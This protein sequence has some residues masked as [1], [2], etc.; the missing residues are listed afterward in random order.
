[1]S[2]ADAV[3]TQPAAAGGHRGGLLAGARR[4]HRR[5]R[6]RQGAHLRR[7]PARVPRP[8]RSTR[9]GTTYT[10]SAVVMPTTV[11]EIQE[12]L[13]VANEHKVPLWT[14]GTGPQQRLR[15]ARAAR[16]RL[17]DREPAQHEPRARD[18]RGVRLRRRRARRALVRPLRGDPGRRPPADA[19]DRRPRLGQRRS[20]TR[21]TTASPTCPTAWT[22]AC[23]AAWRSCSPTA[24]SCAPAW[25]RCP[26]T[27][28]GTST[29]AASGPT[30]DQL[31]MQSNYGIVTKMG[32]WLMPY[33]EVYMPLWLRVWKDDDLAPVVDTLRTLMLDG[34]IRMVPQ[35][36]NTVLLGSVLS[37]RSQ[38]WRRRRADPGRRHRPDGARARDRALDACASRSTAT[39]RWSTTASPRSRRRSSA[40]RAPRCG[41]PSARPRTSRASST[42]PSASRAACRT[43]SWNNMTGLVRRRGGRPH[44][45]LAGRAAHRPR[46]ARRCAT[47]CAG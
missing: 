35:I 3:S 9:P 46:R 15:R 10:A 36:L 14:H 5:P 34:T 13:R 29:S 42:R 37:S 16:A 25:A 41:A 2:Q 21:S 31:F 24:T 32:V 39:R 43:S 23:S 12:V 7:R 40:S 6:R 26:T 28:P 33:P 17:G 8:V 27:S 18:Q 1:M 38:W 47:C 11:E 20:A 44:R 19:L 30:P 45:L 4:L 22:W